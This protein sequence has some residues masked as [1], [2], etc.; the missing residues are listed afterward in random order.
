[1]RMH[2]HPSP[3]AQ[4]LVRTLVPPLTL[5]L[6][7]TMLPHAQRTAQGRC[8]DAR[9][10][11]GLFACGYGRGAGCFVCWAFLLLCIAL[12][13]VQLQLARSSRAT[14][15]ASKQN[16]DRGQKHLCMSVL[17]FTMA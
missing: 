10:L 4:Q 17:L 9:T 2:G 7:F 15:R 14:P 5:F 12:R 8:A 1:M 16:C 3:D 13:L 6:T 11:E